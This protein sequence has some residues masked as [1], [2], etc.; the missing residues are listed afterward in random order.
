M[1]KLNILNTIYISPWR[2]PSNWLCNIRQL[3][4]LPKYGWQRIT[5]GYCDYDTWNLD[6]YYSNLISSSIMYLR[7]HTHGYPVEFQ[8]FEEWQDTLFNIA[9]NLSES[10]IDV[11]DL[12]DWTVEKHDKLEATRKAQQNY[13][14]DLLKKYYDNLWD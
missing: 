7:E 2:Y 9:K 13:A 8:T 5:R 4:R 1:N 3:L 6:S 11:L 14:L 12:K 10:N